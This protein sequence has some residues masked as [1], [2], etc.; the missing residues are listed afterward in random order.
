MIAVASILSS[1]VM[2]FNASGHGLT[3]T[4]RQHR[5]QFFT[6]LLVSIDRALI[7]RSLESRF[8][9]QRPMKLKL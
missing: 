7:K 8:P 2:A 4:H 5:F 3:Q 1:P 9:A 6:S